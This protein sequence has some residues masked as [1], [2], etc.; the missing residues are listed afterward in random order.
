MARVVRKVSGKAVRGQKKDKG[1]L[2]DKRFWAICI[3]SLLL[4]AAIITTVVI[5]VNNNN[6]ATEEVTVEDYFGTTQTYKDKVT[7]EEHEVNFEKS[8]YGAARLHSN[9]NFE[10]SWIE[11]MFVFAIDLSTFYPMDLYDNDGKNLK[12]ST[13]EEVFNLLMK[14]QVEIDKFNESNEAEYDV[15]LLIIDTKASIYNESIGILADANFGGSEEGDTTVLF[16]LITEDGFV[17]SYAGEKG[18][19][20][21]DALPLSATT[22]TKSAFQSAINNSI[23]FM[24]LGF[25]E[26]N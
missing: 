23:N 19:E 21:K 2:K 9:P 14:L 13:H 3:L 6:D 26:Q 5:V 10:E 11:Y 22:L 1:L 7:G 4:I 8:T 20:N 16:S 17:P 25:K 18:G 15:R 24:N 12:N